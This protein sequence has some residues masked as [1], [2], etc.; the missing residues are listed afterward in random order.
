VCV[1]VVLARGG[2]GAGGDTDDEQARGYALRLTNRL[3]R[4]CEGALR[5]GHAYDDSGL[6]ISEE[7]G[8]GL[9][10]DQ[11]AHEAKR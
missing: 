10:R 8:C 1:G 11:Q 3:V 5:R 9:G 6:D 2:G 7:E 4:L